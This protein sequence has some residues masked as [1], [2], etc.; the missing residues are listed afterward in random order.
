MRD[1]VEYIARA[2]V[3]DPS[4]VSVE[5]VPGQ[6]TT[7]YKLRVA[8]QDI[9]KVIGKDGRT[10]RSIRAVLSAAAAKAHKRAVLEIVE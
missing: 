5:E 4:Q 6:K 7:V 8:S 2:L 9:G 1:L 10:A 3:D